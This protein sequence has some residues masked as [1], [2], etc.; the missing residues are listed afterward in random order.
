MAADD[1]TQPFPPLWGCSMGMR[2]HVYLFKIV[3]T[4]WRGRR[5]TRGW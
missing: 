3:Y 2:L 1:H 5:R 4:Y